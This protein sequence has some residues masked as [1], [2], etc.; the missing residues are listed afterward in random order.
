MSEQ[1]QEYRMCTRGIWDTS[2]P[3]IEFD[4]NGVSNYAK[5]FDKL[6]EA[7]PRGEKGKKDWENI[8]DKIKEKGK[9]KRFKAEVITIFYFINIIFLVS[10]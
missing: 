2:V 5:I 9:G 7:Y 6:C 1:N 10:V 4:E 3:G 8:V